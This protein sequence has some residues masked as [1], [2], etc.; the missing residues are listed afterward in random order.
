MNSNISFTLSCIIVHTTR[1]SRYVWP[2]LN[3]MHEKGQLFFIFM[4]PFVIRT[5][6]KQVNAIIKAISYSIKKLLK[7]S[8]QS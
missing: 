4:F 5:I 1:F 8:L 2:F 6:K 3:V 7:D